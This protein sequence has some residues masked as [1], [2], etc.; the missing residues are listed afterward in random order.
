MPWTATERAWRDAL[1]AAMIDAPQTLPA[2]QD[3]ALDRFWP[4]FEAHAPLHLA[5]GFRLA[6]FLIAGALPWLLLRLKTLPHLSP[7]GRDAVLQRANRLPLFKDL[8]E[9]VK[10]IA[11]LAYFDDEEVQDRARGRR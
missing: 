6:T 2:G 10:I 8:L 4:R 11:C 1:I 7:G 5:W 3:V 9:I